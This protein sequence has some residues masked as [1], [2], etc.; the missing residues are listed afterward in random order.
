MLDV[1][2][3]QLPLLLIHKVLT[4]T[5][6]GNDHGEWSLDV[7]IPVVRFYSVSLHHTTYNT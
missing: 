5:A 7:K 1:R 2:V 6:I 3:R 4:V